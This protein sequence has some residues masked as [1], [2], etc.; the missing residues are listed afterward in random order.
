M[1]VELVGRR[2]LKLN[3]KGMLPHAYKCTYLYL[4]QTH[5]TSSCVILPRLVSLTLSSI[6]LCNL[7]AISLYLL[8]GFVCRLFQKK[9]VTY[10]LDLLEGKNKKQ[11]PVV[12]EK[13]DHDIWISVETL[14]QSVD[15]DEYDSDSDVIDVISGNFRLLFFFP[16][17]FL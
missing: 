1:C 3:I 8:M 10:L 11:S 17:Y 12:S 9:P 4:L 6:N 7:F 16:H 5:S 2:L 15:E 13:D 14:M